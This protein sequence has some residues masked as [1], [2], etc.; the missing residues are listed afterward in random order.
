MVTH[1]ECQVGLTLWSQKRTSYGK[2]S[3]PKGVWERSW[4]KGKTTSSQKHS[5]FT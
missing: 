3:S 2:V 5:L 1:L 4:Q